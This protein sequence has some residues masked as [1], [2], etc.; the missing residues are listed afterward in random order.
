MSRQLTQFAIAL[1][2]SIGL[3]ASTLA[4]VIAELFFDGQSDLTLMLVGGLIGGNGQAVA[5]LFR[6]N[7]STKPL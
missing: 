5:F 4:A 1:T 7:N 2:L 3:A 6:T